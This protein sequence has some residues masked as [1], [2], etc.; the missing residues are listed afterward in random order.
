M[1]IT[2]DQELQVTLERMKQFQSQVVKLRH[3]EE[4]PENYRLSASGFLAELDRMTLQVREYLWSHPA[5]Q[6]PE[7][8]V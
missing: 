5:E 7:P 4:N 3:T 8:A 2:N 1:M 6:A